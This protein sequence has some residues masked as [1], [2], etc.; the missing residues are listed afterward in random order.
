MNI[1]IDIY[2]YTYQMVFD[3]LNQPH[4]MSWRTGMS[5]IYIL[6][7]YIY[8]YIL[9][10]PNVYIYIW[11]NAV[12][13]CAPTCVYVWMC[14]CVRASVCECMCVN[15]CMCMCICI[16]R[17]TC[18]YEDGTSIHLY[19]IQ[20]SCMHSQTRIPTGS[21]HGFWRIPIYTYIYTMYGHPKSA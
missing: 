9:H 19:Y 11:I 4:E 5:Y 13:E 8:I 7:Y 18:L 17:R 20:Y 12:C 2:M 21:I 15:V 16:C 6:S 10:I 3:L 14:V 1:N